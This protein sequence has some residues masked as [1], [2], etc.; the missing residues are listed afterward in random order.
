MV[1][2][3]CDTECPMSRMTTIASCKKEKNIV[4]CIENKIYIPDIL[5][6]IVISG[7]YCP[8]HH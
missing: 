5:H 8:A 2:V 1:S 7:C 6:L 4:T 3:S